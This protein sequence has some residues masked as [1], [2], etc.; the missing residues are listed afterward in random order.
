VQYGA[1]KGQS[2]LVIATTLGTGIGSAL[3]MDGVL[4]PNTELGHLE[5][6]GKDAERYAS[7]A[8]RSRKE[9]TWEKW[10]ER[11]TKY[12][13][14]LEKYFSPELFVVGGGVSKKS[15]KFFPFI[16]VSTS[17]VAAGL[18]NDA[19]IIGAASFAASH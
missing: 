3:I 14:M 19:G 18:L 12:Y 8:A 1:A 7:D 5:L 4:I 2:G 10:G 15:E 16:D 9:L 13:Q 11:L 17:L 6:N